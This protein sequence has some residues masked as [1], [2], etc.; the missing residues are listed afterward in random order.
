MKR[1]RPRG[2]EEEKVKTA[3]SK[4]K[5]SRGIFGKSEKNGDEEQSTRK[6]K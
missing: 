1:G 4:S 6:K 3:N 5:K 2:R